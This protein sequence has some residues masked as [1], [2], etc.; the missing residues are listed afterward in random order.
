LADLP[1]LDA[2]RVFL[3][4][5]RHQS[6][7]KAAGALNVTQG[8]VS[9]RIRALEE[10]LGTPLFHRTRRKVTLTEEGRTLARAAE[11]AFA[12]LQAGLDQVRSQ[13]QEGRLMVSCS[14]SFAIRWLVPH[15]PELQA[16]QPGLAVL[17]SAEDGLVEPG[18]EGIDV[19]IRYGPGGTPGVDE[20]ALSVEQVTPVC[21]PQL[22]HRGPPLRVPADLAQHTLLHDEV[23]RG[24]PGRVG[25]ER[26]L[27]AAG[28]TG[29]DARKGLRFSH[30]HM[31]LEAALAGQGVALARSILV[32]RDL[33]EGRLVAPFPDITVPSGLG[34]YVLTARG[35]LRP[36]VLAFRDWL[37][38]GVGER[39]A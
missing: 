5:A 17:I 37:V 8:A 12:T 10:E 31:A 28:V 3:A 4:A 2:L 26:W 9:H 20:R 35:P 32:A 13:N 14:P 39:R 6:F 19:C 25:W 22:L 11:E 29:V 36:A 15:L 7:S 30:A 21:S 23:L 1:S 18:S 34:Y 16:A 27:K 33:A 24:H 38:A